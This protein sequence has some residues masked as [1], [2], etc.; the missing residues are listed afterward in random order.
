MASKLKNLLLTG[1]TLLALASNAEASRAYE[2]CAPEQAVN[3]SEVSEPK[4]PNRLDSSGAD[5]VWPISIMAFL[6]F[7]VAMYS[8][9]GSSNYS[10]R[11][12]GTENRNYD[13]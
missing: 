5:I 7:A 1:T 9:V 10:Q 4:K 6:T 3:Y 2:P 11:Q 8:R 12:K 13:N